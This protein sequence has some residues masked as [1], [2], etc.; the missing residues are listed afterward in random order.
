MSYYNL[1]VNNDTFEKLRNEDYLWW[2]NL[3]K[4]KNISIQ[5]RKDN[6]LDVYYNGG[7]ILSDLK[8]IKNKNTFTAKIHP[9]YIPLEDDKNTQSLKLCS[10]GVE[11]TGKIDKMALNN[12]DDKTIKAITDR[13]KYYFG[14]ESEKAIQY[15][16][17]VIDDFIIDTEYQVSSS[18]IRV[19]LIRL[20]NSVKKLVFIEVKRM[21]DPRLFFE[22]TE[23]NIYDQLKKYYDFICDDSGKLLEYYK[24]VLQIKKNLGLAK[25]GLKNIE[26]NDDWKVECKPLLVFGDCMQA[27]INENSEIIKQKIEKIACGAFYF[28]KPKPSLDLNEKSKNKHIF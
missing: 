22:N 4:N 8:Y 11:F 17:A 7:A 13:I 3:K 24:K 2:E 20:D 26:L 28:N 15:K 6:T 1:D 16:Y 9:K 5:I 23:G 10:S 18:N 14:S 21:E 25:E 19:D 12:F 27:W